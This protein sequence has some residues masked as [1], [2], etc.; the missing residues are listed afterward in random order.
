ML[1][2]DVCRNASSFSISAHKRVT[3][4]SLLPPERGTRDLG[5]CGFPSRQFP[6]QLSFFFFSL[7]QEETLWL[8]YSGYAQWIFQG[9][10]S[11]LFNSNSL[12]LLLL[13]PSLYIYIL[14]QVTWVEHVEMEENHVHQI[15]NHYVS[16]GM[17]FGAQR[18]L[19]VLQRQCERIASLMARNISD[20]GG[21]FCC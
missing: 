10:L 9:K 18:W 11:S 7:L 17:A 19:A 13:L 20:L 4:P 6:S 16:S 2:T 21:M 15:F 8:H 12:L 5:Y 3:F 1:S 14:F